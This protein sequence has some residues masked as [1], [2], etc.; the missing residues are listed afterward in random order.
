MQRTSNGTP[1]WIDGSGPPVVLIHGVMMDH[2]MWEP[3]VRALRDAYTVI[4]YDMLGHGQAPDAQGDRTLDEFVAQAREVI[5]E[6]CP[7]QRPVL[8]GFSM[9]GLVTQ[10]VAASHWTELKAVLLL[11]TVFERSEAQSDAVAYRLGL[12]EQGGVESVVEPAMQR[13]FNEQEKKHRSAEIDEIIGWM[14]DDD[15]A[16]KIKAYRVFVNSDSPSAQALRKVQCPALV[17]TGDGD[18]GSTAQMSR[19]MAE[20]LPHAELHIQDNQQHMMPFLDADR[21]NPILREFLDRFNA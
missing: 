15:F 8:G 20:E 21:V 13:W 9:G 16:P 1:V 17:M 11:N 2:R 14:R 12:M 19:R 3:Q 5:A 18:V 4:R 10:T 7:S 6:C